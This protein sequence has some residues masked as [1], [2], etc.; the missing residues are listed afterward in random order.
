[1][2]RFGHPGNL[3]SGAAGPRRGDEDG[4]A[5]ALCYGD[6]LDVLRHEIAI[7]LSAARALSGCP[8]QSGRE[9]FAATEEAAVGE[10]ARAV[11]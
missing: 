5:N 4:M 8:G 6:N 10:A 1:M 3:I 2:R 11:G 9:G 7:G